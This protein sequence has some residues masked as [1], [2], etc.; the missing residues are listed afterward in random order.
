MTLSPKAAKTV[1]IGLI[2]RSV[3]KP[4]HVHR[5]IPAWADS[6]PT[7]PESAA[8]WRQIFEAQGATH[9]IRQNIRNPQ[10][11]RL[12]TLR[13]ILC[14]DTFPEYLN[15]LQPSLT[16]GPKSEP[17]ATAEQ[18][19]QGPWSSELQQLK[20]QNPDIAEVLDESRRKALGA[21]VKAFPN[22]APQATSALWA[23]AMPRG[24]WKIQPQG[25][26]GFFEPLQGVQLSPALEKFC[27]E[28]GRELQ[29]NGQP[30]YQIAAACRA[31]SSGGRV[32]AKLYDDAFGPPSEPR[33][34]VPFL[35]LEIY[36][37]PTLTERIKKVWEDF[38]ALTSTTGFRQVSAGVATV[39]IVGFVWQ[40]L[41]KPSLLGE[42]SITLEPDHCFL[43]EAEPESPAAGES[44]QSQASTT[45]AQPPLQT[46]LAS[47]AP[48]SDPERKKFLGQLL[49]LTKASRP[50]HLY[51]G[52]SSEAE[53]SKSILRYQ[54]GLGFD[55]P[56]GKI[57]AD[58]LTATLLSSDVDFHPY[59][60]VLDTTLNSL[61]SAAFLD[62]DT[63]IRAIATALNRD[64]DQALTD[65]DLAVRLDFN[66]T[67]LPSGESLKEPRPKAQTEWKNSLDAWSLSLNENPEFSDQNLETLARTLIQEVQYSTTVGAIE[68][69]FNSEQIPGYTDEDEQKLKNT[70]VKVLGLKAYPLEPDS[71]D[72]KKALLDRVEAYNSK[73]GRSPVRMFLNPE[74]VSSA[75]TR[76]FE[77]FKA[78]VQREFNRSCLR[79]IQRQF[80]TPLPPNPPTP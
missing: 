10:M 46:T 28:V 3:I 12:L 9:A 23:W 56:D 43:P 13:A 74:T 71:P 24:F 59:R 2:S 75:A 26:D 60:L 5:L 22:A 62:R 38:L 39:L 78:E 32:E 15:W 11:V 36:R 80:C 18:F 65:Y 66:S 6:D 33:E 14:P 31:Y 45:E 42:E 51:V 35:G 73:G 55:N 19:L 44:N 54:Q 77:A 8:F 25:W 53:L 76:N 29:R 17:Q 68:S 37:K 20:D 47:I 70:I 21:V 79:P 34:G 1:I 27:L 58:G 7:D 52:P 4:E 64:S 67:D 16:S 48:E 40:I 30:F 69:L 57:E 49:C 61:S 63:A 50:W 41:S 72:N